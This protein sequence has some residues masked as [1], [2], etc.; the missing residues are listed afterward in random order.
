MLFFVVVVVGRSVFWGEGEGGV[1]LEGG[2][3]FFFF[4]RE[5]DWFRTGFQY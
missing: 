5:K 4:K 2:Y 1:W 3:F